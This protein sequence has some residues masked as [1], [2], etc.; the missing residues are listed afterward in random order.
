M[1][2]KS[3]GTFIQSAQAGYLRNII[4]IPGNVT[5]NSIKYP[6]IVE[7]RLETEAVDDLVSG[8]LD[9]VLLPFL[10]LKKTRGIMQ[11]R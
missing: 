4:N 1:S 9:A 5:E 11:L 6:K 8:K 7:Y 2:G 10:S 3:I